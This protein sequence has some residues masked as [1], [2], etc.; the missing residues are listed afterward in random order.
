MQVVLFIARIVDAKKSNRI[1]QIVEKYLNWRKTMETCKLCVSIPG[2][3]LKLDM[4]RP[5]AEVWFTTLVDALLNAPEPD[6]EPDEGTRVER[7]YEDD[8]DLVEEDASEE[9]GEPEDAQDTAPPKS[10]IEVKETRSRPER[11]QDDQDD[12]EGY[13][14][15]LRIRCDVC[16]EIRGF[17]ARQRIRSSWCPCGEHTPLIDLDKIVARCSACGNTWVYRTNN[18]EPIDEIICL[19]CGA[20]ITLEQDKHGNYRTIERE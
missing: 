19:E 6:Q 13:K 5:D 20:P 17:N 1:A 2:K 15:F 14:G 18:T 7:E 10:V 8:E 16:G 9:A 3:S 11:A 4:P 12:Q